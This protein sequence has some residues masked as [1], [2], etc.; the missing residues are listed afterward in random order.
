MRNGSVRALMVGLLLGGCADPPVGQPDPQPFVVEND[1]VWSGS[2]VTVRSA[3]FVG[4]DPAAVLLDADTLAFTRVNDSTLTVALPDL[5]GTHQLHIASPSVLPTPVPVH[6]NG[7]VGAQEGPVFM[8][9]AVRGSQLTEVYGS[10]PTGLRRW[11]VSTGTTWD[12]PDSMHTGT[13][14]RGVGAG[15]HTGELVL[16]RGDCSVANWWLWRI[17]PTVARLD[18]TQFGSS[19]FVDVLGP[20]RYVLPGAHMTVIIACDTS[21]VRSDTRGESG[22][23]VVHSPTGHRAVPLAYVVSD[24]GAPVIDGTTGRLSY[25]LPQFEELIGAAFSEDGDTLYLTGQDNV[26]TP[27]VELLLAARAV[28]GSPLVVDTLSFSPCGVA[29]DPVRP[30]L[31]VAGNQGAG[32]NGR[33]VLGVFDRTTLE[34]I[35]L[36]HADSLVYY[37]PCKVL[38]S[39]LERRVYVIPSIEGAFDI[40]VHSWVASYETPP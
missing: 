8:G 12:Y 22:F 10:G 28:D 31:Y 20:G 18:S 17:E 39:P 35:A 40:R 15:P 24:T 11:D 29:V 3:G 26:W 6:L 7:F 23:D 38:P 30:L 9:R 1:D 32:A 27:G 33:S 4:A 36:L 14:S 37:T 2:S 19:W 13:C 5:P 16:L 21:C 34:P 25:Y